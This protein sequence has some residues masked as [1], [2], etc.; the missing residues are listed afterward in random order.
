MNLA[1]VLLQVVPNNIGAT[2]D[3]DFK[4]GYNS[5]LSDVRQAINKVRIS[6]TELAKRLYNYLK[7]T[8]VGDM[9]NG[10]IDCLPVAKALADSVGD[11][12]VK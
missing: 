2:H 4:D 1:E 11:W 3:I 8:P 6:E 7:D 10:W 5:A 12:V 9:L